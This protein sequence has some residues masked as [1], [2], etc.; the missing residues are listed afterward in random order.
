MRFPSKLT[1]FL[2]SCF[3]SVSSLKYFESSFTINSEPSFTTLLTSIVPPKVS[4]ALY[5]IASPSPFPTIPLVVVSFSRSKGLKIRSM[6]Y[7]EIPLPSSRIE[8]V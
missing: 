7:G 6:K 5:V 1:V 8:I 3:N 2:I 4:T